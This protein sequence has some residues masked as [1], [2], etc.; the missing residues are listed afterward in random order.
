MA[1]AS[2]L[3]ASIARV[4]FVPQTP[5]SV[6]GGKTS[7]SVESNTRAMNEAETLEKN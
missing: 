5:D 6:A 2:V 7:D 3:T 1:N 4:I